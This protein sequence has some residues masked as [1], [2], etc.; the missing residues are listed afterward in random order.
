MNNDLDMNEMTEEELEEDIAMYEDD[1]LAGLLAAADDNISETLEISVTR[2]KKKF[3]SFRVH[4]LSEE[5]LT[6]IRK[7]YTKHSKKRRNGIKVSEEIDT[8]RYRASIIYNSTVEE[9]QKKLWDNKEVWK[10]L[11]SKG[12]VIVDALDVI[13]AVLLPGE[14]AQILDIIDEF[15]GY[16][17]DEDEKTILAK[18]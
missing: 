13:E 12:Y 11:S 10:A 5:T 9:D 3:F 1:Y 2:K 16:V 4:T 7:M 8:W 6:G 15:N 14:K 17:D 18:N